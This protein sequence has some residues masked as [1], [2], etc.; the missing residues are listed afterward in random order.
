M[1]REN[2]KRK[3]F[4]CAKDSLFFL[5]S[6]PRFYLVSRYLVFTSLEILVRSGECVCVCVCVCVCMH[7]RARG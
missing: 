1:R 7:E 3:K 2:G 5:L 4:L 6:A